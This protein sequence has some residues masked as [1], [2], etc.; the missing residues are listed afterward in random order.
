MTNQHPRTAVPAS[1]QD[2]ARTTAASHNDV[3]SPTWALARSWLADL[4]HVVGTEP[5]ISERDAHQLA[6][7]WNVS[8]R[9][10]WR[11]VAAF[12]AERGVRALLPAKGGR[13]GGVNRLG[14]PIESIIRECARRWW[15]QT[16]NATIAE[17]YP[18]VRGEC[19][20]RDVHAPS[21]ASVARRLKVLRDDPALFP[22]AVAAKLRE[23]KRLSKASYVVEAPL[24][25]VQVD[26]TVADVFVVDPVTRACIGRPTLTVAVDVATRCVLGFCL[27]L[28]APS[29]LLVALCLEHAVAPKDAWLAARGIE[30]I[31]P[32]QGIPAALHVDNG[33]EFHSAAFRRGCDLNGIDVIYRP[34]GTPRF[35]GHVERLIGTLMRRVRLLPGYSYSDLLKARPTRAE[36]RAQ[37]TLRELEVFL[38][39]DIAR[40]HG[41]VHRSLSLSPRSVWERHWAGVSDRPSLSSDPTRFRLEFLPAFSR[42]VGREGIELFALHYACEA[43]ALEVERSRPRTIRLDPRDLARVY[44]EREKASPLMIP[45]RDRRLPPMSL[46]EWNAIR[47]GRAAGAQVD[48]EQVATELTALAPE[49]IRR[50]I[51]LRGARRLARQ[52]AAREIQALSAL[53]VPQV[54]LTATLSS[55]NVAAL[56]W[57]VLE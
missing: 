6:M 20:A 15:T 28:E 13:P 10:V 24:A 53:P 38:A 57:E 22:P 56:P 2:V 39:E 49:S 8:V 47:K 50:Q 40:Y 19:R 18:T 55:D 44:L 54:A 7:K 26:H 37:L 31:W 42:V 4:R 14:E 12:R 16:E 23:R 52:A 36:R 46:W 43:L 17:I 35:G 9:T 5:S 33:R 32:M 51:T 3:D 48:A 29:A 1:A 11:R 30:A 45:L 41:Q 34:P 27:S 21:R 25:V